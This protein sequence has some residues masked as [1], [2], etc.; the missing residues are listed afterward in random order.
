M[1]V[2]VEFGELD[3]D[4]KALQSNYD[5]GKFLDDFI[6][7]PPTTGGDPAKHMRTKEDAEQSGERWLREMEGVSYE[8]REEGVYNK[9]GGYC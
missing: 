3:S 1:P 2:E 4:S 9:E 5:P 6:V 8:K 7:K